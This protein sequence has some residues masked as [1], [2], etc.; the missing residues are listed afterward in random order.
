MANPPG[1]TPDSV[2]AK[3]ADKPFAFDFFAAVRRLQSC[4]PDLPRIGHSWSPAQDPLRFAQSPSLDFAPATLESL[5]HK[6][7]DRAPV[8]YSRHF[9]LLGPNGPLPLCYTEY[10]RERVLHHGDATFAAFCNVFHHR[11]ISFFFRAWA[12]AQKTVDFDRPDGQHWSEFMASLVGLGM[13]SLLQR[14]SVPDR[15]KL[16]FAGRLAQQTRNAEGLEAIVQEFFGLRTEL[17]T[18]VRRWLKLPAES[19]CRLGVSSETGTLGASVILGSRFWTCQLHFRLRLG[20]LSLAEYERMLPTGSSFRRLRDWVRQYAG[21]HY[22]WDVQ[23]VLAK[24]EVP[25]IQI[26]VAG[27]LGW[28]TW[29]KTLPFGRNAEDLILEPAAAG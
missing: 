14:E 18:F 29:L 12:D 27:R 13:D 25:A 6:V 26:G 4:Y 11:L 21:E 8:L 2:I 10:A 1:P 20:P 16:Y 15:A 22:S 3:L 17:Q 5:Q 28:T 7:P 24:E 23:L 19:V 9:G